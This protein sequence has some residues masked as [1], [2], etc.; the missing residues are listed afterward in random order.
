[1]RFILLL[2][3]MIFS[4][5]L[6]YAQTIQSNIE[7]VNI[8]LHCSIYNKARMSGAAG[9]DTLNIKRQRAIVSA[10]LGKLKALYTAAQIPD[11][12]MDS[13]SLAGITSPLIAHELVHFQQ[14]NLPG[15][16]SLLK[17]VLEEG[18][19]DFI[20]ELISGKTPNERLYKWAKG[21]EMQLWRDFTNDMY[22]D[23]T[24]DWI[25]NQNLETPDKPANIG[26]WIGYQICQAYYESSKNKQQA[27]N[28][29]LL[30]KNYKAFY[31]KSNAE[32]WIR[33]NKE[34]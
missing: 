29:M 26:Y 17:I 15:G 18:M 23:K 20:G 31:E 14:N 5:H 28:D 27:I 19:A 25:N 34:E 16:H 32:T 2:A 22:Q 21:R 8:L 1:M 30:I 24:D 6:V 7:Q 12:Y 9:K 33:K 4:F 10:C 13:L 3:A 11:A